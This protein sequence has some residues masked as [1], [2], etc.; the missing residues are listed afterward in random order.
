MRRIRSSIRRW[1]IRRGLR[2]AFSRAETVEVEL[3]DLRLVILSD[4]HRGARDGAD[5]FAA[6]EENH[7]AALGYY[8]EADYRLLVLGDAEELWEC[9]PEEVLREYEHNLRLEARFLPDRYERFWGN[10]DDPW[11]HRGEVERHL[12]SLLPGLRVREALKLRL[13]GGPPGLLF[14][15]HGHQGT[16]W[17]DHLAFLSRFAVRY[18]W[19]WLQ[20][21]LRFRSVTPATDFRLR[22]DHERAMLEWAS[23]QRPGLVLI[24][25]HTHRPVF[26][27]PRSRPEP[28]RSSGRI[29]GELEEARAGGTDPEAVAM[30]R[31]ELELARAAELRSGEGHRRLPVRGGPPCYFNTGACSFADGTVTGIELAE[32][33]IRLVR[34]QTGHEERPERRI[35]ERQPLAEVLEALG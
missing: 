35:L 5:D 24:T 29:K 10:H 1:R 34:W 32:E 14:L 4:L 33:E 20:R 30:L 23:A 16:L 18:P 25:G 6:C 17:S 9:R 31:A 21:I 19:R 7:S 3:P 15:A 27:H 28:D 26:L 2:G 13:M 8:L 11:R 22:H 12:Q